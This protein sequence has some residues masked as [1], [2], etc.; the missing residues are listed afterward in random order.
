MKREEI[1]LLKKKYKKKGYNNKEISKKIELHNFLE[2]Q[3][4][5]SLITKEQPVNYFSS[6]PVN[7]NKKIKS[8]YSSP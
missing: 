5:S 4:V 7:L 3:Y 6:S 8:F 1:E 2:K